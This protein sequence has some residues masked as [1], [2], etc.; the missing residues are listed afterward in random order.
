MRWP[1][2]HV[3]GNRQAAHTS[4][5]EMNVESYRRRMAYAAATSLSDTD[6]ESRSDTE[7]T[8]EEEIATPDSDIAT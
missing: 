8:E 2:E 7:R 1:H 4:I 5:F 6:R 3:R